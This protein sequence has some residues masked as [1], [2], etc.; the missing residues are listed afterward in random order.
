M[1]G[2]GAWLACVRWHRENLQRHQL[3]RH[4]QFSGTSRVFYFICNC[5]L[6]LRLRRSSPVSVPSMYWCSYERTLSILRSGVF[7]LAYHCSCPC[8]YRWMDSISLV[9]VCPLWMSPCRI[10]R[11]CTKKGKIKMMTRAMIRWAS[12]LA[13]TSEVK[14]QCKEREIIKVKHDECE[15]RQI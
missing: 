5:I 1:D 7:A 10:L 2:T 14:R 15:L 3:C 4:G 11:P 13:T 6:K 8:A 9:T 12:N